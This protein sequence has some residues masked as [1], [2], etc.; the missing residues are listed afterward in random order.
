M[1]QFY[2][3]FFSSTNHDVN[4]VLLDDFG[5]VRAQITHAVLHTQR[6]DFDCNLVLIQNLIIRSHV[7]LHFT[8]CFSILIRFFLMELR[9]VNRHTGSVDA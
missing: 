7:A 1:Y 2:D 5:R 4:L 6:F 3:L 8:L 9:R